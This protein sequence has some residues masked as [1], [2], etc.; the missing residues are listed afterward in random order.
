MPPD[1]F[2]GVI[3]EPVPMYSESYVMSCFPVSVANKVTNKRTKL[4]THVTKNNTLY[5]S[6]QYFQ[7]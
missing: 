5:K 2:S 7:A 1:K 3:P 4:G 6:Y